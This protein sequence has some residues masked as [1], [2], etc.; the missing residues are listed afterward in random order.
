MG[1]SLGDRMKYYETEWNFKIPD[2]SSVIIRVDGRAFHTLTKNAN[3]PFDLE[4]IECMQSAAI[5]TAKELGAKLAYVQSD[6]VSFLLSD[7]D[8]PETQPLF[9]NRLN[10]LQSISAATMSVAFANDLYNVP[11]LQAESVLPTFDS[12]AFAV[13]SED[14]PNYFI[15]RQKDWLR[16]SVQMLAQSEFS[17]VDVQ[18]VSCAELKNKLRARGKSWEARPARQKYGS[19]ITKS[20]RVIN[21]ELAYEDISWYLDVQLQNGKNPLLF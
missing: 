7:L 16:N 10:K 4:F 1:D 11:H 19:F 5:Y 21:A 8:R 12:R 18:N 3:K 9:G 17:W 13:P 14:V 20:G 2:N 15:W 6:E